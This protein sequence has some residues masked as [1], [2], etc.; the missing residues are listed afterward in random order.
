MKII[1]KHYDRAL[2]VLIATI[3][4]IA[5]S[6]LTMKSLALEEK[7]S[8]TIPIVC[9]AFEMP[10]SKGLDAEWA[11]LDRVHEWTSSTP[12]R[13]GMTSTLVYLVDGELVSLYGGRP[14]RGDVPNPYFPEHDLPIERSDVLSLDPDGDGFTIGEEF[15]GNTDPNDADSHPDLLLKLGLAR[16]T[17][18]SYSL[19][20]TG[21]TSEESSIKEYRNGINWRATWLKIG[22][23]FADGR[24]KLI[25]AVDG[26]V[27]VLDT[28]TDEEIELTKHESKELPIFRAVFDYPISPASLSGK[29]FGYGES[30]AIPDSEIRCKVQAVDASSVTLMVE[31]NGKA[32][33]ELQLQAK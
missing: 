10:E 27:T 24:Y 7:I 19:R 16:V 17:S 5:G 14:L 8:P 18:E 1:R 9:P 21:Q 13:P 3:T 15:K 33:E 25:A 11:H 4:L 28:R 30:F 26:S 23:T 12:Q 2:L 31:R 29:Q 6:T 32:A 20:L 22:D